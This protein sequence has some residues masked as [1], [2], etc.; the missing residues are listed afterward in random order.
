VL[1]WEPA[2]RIVLVWQL[3]AQFKFDPT[4]RTEVDVR[5]TAIDDRTTQVDLEH[6]GLEAYGADAPAM[7][8]AFDSPNGWDGM[9]EHFALVAA[10]ATPIG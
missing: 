10:G 8:A 7:R 1:V 3:D 6:R 4:L 9:L 5:F 2:R